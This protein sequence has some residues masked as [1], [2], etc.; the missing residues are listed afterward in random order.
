M[1]QIA[2][3]PVKD[4]H[5]PVAEEAALAQVN[6]EVKDRQIQRVAAAD[7]VLKNAFV[8][9]QPQPSGISCIEI[10]EAQ[11]F[12]AVDIQ[13]RVWYHFL[14]QSRACS[15]PIDTKKEDILCVDS[16]RY[17]N[18][19]LHDSVLHSLA[20]TSAF[21]A[22]PSVTAACEPIQHHLAPFNNYSYELHH[23]K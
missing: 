22:S 16:R 8:G 18:R 13:F 6:G 9:T 2:D 7:T 23:L 5:G 4:S 20:T 10:L 1:Y 21:E 19:Q 17:F 11:P 15:E 14:Q 3:A 12:C